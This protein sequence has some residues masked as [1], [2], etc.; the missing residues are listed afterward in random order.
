[1]CIRDSPSGGQPI[2]STVDIIDFSNDTATTTVRGNISR[3]V[4]ALS[5]FSGGANA[6][7]QFGG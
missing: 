5:A 4:Y 7:P 3:Q 1:M 6:L 2:K